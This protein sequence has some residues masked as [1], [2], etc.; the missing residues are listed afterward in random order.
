MDNFNLKKYLAEGKLLKE[1]DIKEVTYG[2]RYF[3]LVWHSG[4]KTWEDEEGHLTIEVD[5]LEKAKKI[6]KDRYED[7][8]DDSWGVWDNK[9]NKIVFTIGNAQ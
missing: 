7:D 8:T 2:D 4:S 6:A 3:V 5:N 1:L 9:L